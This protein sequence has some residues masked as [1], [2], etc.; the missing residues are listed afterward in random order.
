MLV[1]PVSAR[2]S[3]LHAL[4]RQSRC[5]GAE[6]S[7][8]EAA[9]RA[10]VFP[11]PLGSEPLWMW[12]CGCRRQWALLDTRRRCAHGSR[13]SQRLAVVQVNG[14]FLGGCWWEHRTAGCR[15]KQGSWVLF[16]C[17]FLPHCRDKFLPSRGEKRNEREAK[18][19]SPAPWSHALQAA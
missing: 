3:R 6:P 17:F 14:L 18:K 19:D 4:G 7:R 5:A 12:E 11:S 10:R 16:F 15:S 13:R 9:R 2:R 1:P 8:G